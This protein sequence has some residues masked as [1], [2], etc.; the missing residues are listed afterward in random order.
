LESIHFGRFS[1]GD[2]QRSQ[3]A[4][5]FGVDPSAPVEILG[6]F[7]ARSA[8]STCGRVLLQSR[9]PALGAIHFTARSFARPSGETGVTHFTAV[10]V[11]FGLLPL[12]FAAGKERELPLRTYRL[13]PGAFS[14][15]NFSTNAVTSS[16]KRC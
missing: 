12:Q 14:A 11:D 1:A 13:F 2:V 10:G 4:T 15:S 3:G 9:M 5:G 6:A 8:G 7:V 16:V